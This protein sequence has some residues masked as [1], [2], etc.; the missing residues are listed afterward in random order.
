MSAIVRAQGKIG[1]GI[2]SAWRTAVNCTKAVHAT[3]VAVPVEGKFDRR[4]VGYGTMRSDTT[5]LETTLD[6]TLSIDLQ[7]NSCLAYVLAALFGTDTK[8]VLNTHDYQH[9]L[10][11]DDEIDGE[12]HTL[13]WLVETDETNEIPSVKWT[14]LELVMDVNA[15][16]QLVMTGIG[17]RLVVHT[18]TPQNTAAELL[19]LTYPSGLQDA[20]IGGANHYFRINAY[21]GDALDSGDNIGI[22]GVT[23]SLSRPLER[24]WVLSGA[25]TPYTTEPKHNAAYAMGSL[26]VRYAEIDSSVIDLQADWKNRTKKKAELFIDGDQIAGDVGNSNASY[27]FAFPYME[28]AQAPAGFDYPDNAGRMEPTQMYDLLAP[29]AAPTGM[30]GNTDYCWLTVVNNDS[31]TLV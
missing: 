11:F 31:A 24:Q 20:V 28:P 8:S 4:G 7:Y 27:K 2:G 14:G 26:E 25:D 9:I 5:H 16:P 10:K 19:A 17:D 3:L 13:A 15:V 12:F 18:Q 22:L 30:T 21:S 6:V 29:T 23:V 1:L